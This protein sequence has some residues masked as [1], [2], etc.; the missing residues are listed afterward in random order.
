MHNETNNDD[1]ANPLEWLREIFNP[2]IVEGEGYSVHAETEY[3]DA[4]ITE[5]RVIIKRLE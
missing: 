1:V 2:D 3:D 5:M 4:G